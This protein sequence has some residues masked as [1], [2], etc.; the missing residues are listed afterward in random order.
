VHSDGKLYV[1]VETAGML[2]IYQ[3]IYRRVYAERLALWGMAEDDSTGLFYT[4]SLILFWGLAGPMRAKHPASVALS[5]LEAAD[6]AWIARVD[7]WWR[8]AAL[9]FENVT[10]R[11]WLHLLNGYADI[12]LLRS[13][14]QSKVTLSAIG[15]DALAPSEGF[16]AEWLAQRVLSDFATEISKAF[17]SPASGYLAYDMFEMECWCIAS[18][19]QGAGHLLPDARRRFIQQGLFY[20]YDALD[21]DRKDYFF[22]QYVF[23]IASQYSRAAPSLQQIDAK[24]EEIRERNWRRR[25]HRQWAR[26][27]VNAGA[28]NAFDR[29]QALALDCLMGTARDFDEEKRRLNM[30]FWRSLFALADGLGIRLS[31][32]DTSLEYLFGAIDSN[33]QCIAVDPIFLDAMQVS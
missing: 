26:Q 24:M 11:F 21:P 23:E 20:L 2:P 25:Y 6:A 1:G 10:D 30:R 32:S 7:A 15:A 28:K 16:A 27:Q 33:R 5:R 12:E 3:E 31:A 19:F 4:G 29:R 8:E 18:S 22:D 17:C 13:V 9:N 14:V